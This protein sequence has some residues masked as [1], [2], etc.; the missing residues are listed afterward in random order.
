MNFSQFFIYFL[1]VCV[2]N[3]D[4]L[5]AVDG[6]GA[7]DVY[8]KSCYIKNFGPSEQKYSLSSNTKMII[9]ETGSEEPACPR[10]K[11]AV[12]HAEVVLAKGKGFHKSCA[13]CLTCSKNLDSLSLN[14]GPDGDIYCQSC[15][16]DH[17]GSH[18]GHPY[19]A[20]SDVKITSGG[21]DDGNAEKC[22]RCTGKVFD[23]EKITAG[24]SKL[25]FH[26]TCFNCS[27]CKRSLDQS[28]SDS[29]RIYAFEPPSSVNNVDDQL[30]P[31][32]MYCQRCHLEKFSDQ[33]ARSCNIWSEVSTIKDDKSGCP[34]CGGAV[35]QVILYIRIG[36][37]QF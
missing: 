6:P 30:P 19:S 23:L 12:Y 32:A 28:S 24:R 5:L 8:C 37:Y 1:F 4:Y 31:G 3:L 10:C 29:T 35:F 33:S 15:H 14:T 13:T 7:K 9:P 36:F 20:Y 22:I 18:R 27:E 34:R 26:K 11:G 17:F 16:E 25:V 21:S 2:R